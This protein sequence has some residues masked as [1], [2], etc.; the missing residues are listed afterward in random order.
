MRKRTGTVVNILDILRGR[1]GPPATLPS[2]APPASTLPTTPRIW[3]PDPA[4]TPWFEKPGAEDKAIEVAA[5]WGLGPDGESWLLSWVRNGYFVVDD[6]VPEAVIDAFSAKIDDAWFRDT[7]YGGMSVS[8][9]EVDGV[10]R[11]HTP[12]A[13][14]LA[15]PLHVRKQAK[16][17]SNWRIG[18]YHLHEKTALDVFR[19]E[20]L[21]L[22]C[23]AILDRPDAQPHFSLTFSKGSRQLPHQDTAVFHVWP[24]NSLIGVWIAA[25][26][27]TPDCG[28][29]EYY[30]GSHRV[31]MY[32][33][34]DNY[35]QTQRRTAPTDLAQRYDNYVKDLAAR[36]PRKI[37]TPKKGA[38]LFWHG[39]LVHGGAPVENIDTTRKSFVIHYMP[40]GANRG[41]DIVGPFNW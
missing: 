16:K 2:T 13:E 31:P 18:E 9:V 36:Y 33:E 26:D 29:L 3:V 34:F 40:D 12:H 37:F 20:R 24:A 4:I 5:R 22:I 17:A 14:L 28:P 23:C 35:P 30:P 38:A 8:D 39:M 41:A 21:R 10:K 27:I 11:V 32:H 1:K 15:L 19:S 25:E 7:P 6:A